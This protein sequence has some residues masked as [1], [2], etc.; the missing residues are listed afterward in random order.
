[1][2]LF[3]CN[4]TQTSYWKSCFPAL[5]IDRVLLLR[6]VDRFLTEYLCLCFFSMTLQ[7]HRPQVDSSFRE[8][9]RATSAA[10]SNL[11]EPKENQLFDIW[12]K[13]VFW[14][15]GLSWNCW[16]KKRKR[17]GKTNVKTATCYYRTIHD[18]LQHAAT[19]TQGSFR[20]WR[21]SSNIRT[22]LGRMTNVQQLKD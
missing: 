4:N 19:Y 18:I 20:Q 8:D 9:K 16:V 12:C 11:I 2:L 21:A 14:N 13:L 3:C 10:P 15:A 1:M 5:D 22:L 17:K 7:W 6:N